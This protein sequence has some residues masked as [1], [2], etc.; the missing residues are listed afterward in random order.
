MAE[1]PISHDQTCHNLRQNRYFI[2][3]DWDSDS[4][5]DYDLLDDFCNSDDGCDELFNHHDQKSEV[6]PE[7]VRAM[8]GFLSTKRAHH[9]MK[10]LKVGLCLHNLNPA[11]LNIW[12]D[13]SNR[14]ETPSVADCRKIWNSMKIKSNRSDLEHLHT[15]AQQDNPQ[16]YRTYTHGGL[17]LAIHKSQSCEP[18]DVAQ[19][20]YHIYRY[21]YR[22][23]SIEYNIWQK[24]QGKYWVP[25]MF[26]LTRSRQMETDVIKEYRGLIN[27]YQRL[28]DESP[29]S[30]IKQKCQIKIQKLTQTMNKL[31]NDTSFIIDVMRKCQSL[32]CSI[33]G[34]NLRHRS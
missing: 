13:F 19:V 18:L 1:I 5:D 14:S 3:D 11:F 30:E 9:Y 2:D 15:W 21:K 23:T 16:Q 27:Y 34:I 33:D 28:I 25:V 10:W 7:E 29:S 32:F 20:I 8:V 17:L 26:D 12:I 6:D 31:Q 4:D 24:K 22:C